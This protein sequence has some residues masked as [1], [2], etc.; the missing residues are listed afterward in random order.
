MTDLEKFVALYKSFGIEC[1]VIQKYGRQN[2]LLGG[3]SE[4]STTS[5]LFEG[6]YGTHSEVMFDLDGKFQGQI[7]NA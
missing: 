5:E 7:F 2:I 4:L 1:N 3:D 6:Y